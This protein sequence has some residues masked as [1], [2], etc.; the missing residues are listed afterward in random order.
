[1]RV[2]ER[3]EA[4]EYGKDDV[5]D[6][7]LWKGPKPGEPSWDTAI[8]PGPAGLAHRVLGDEHGP[9]RPVVRHPHRRRRP[10]SS[11]TT[12]TRSPR[13]RRRPAS[14]SCGPGCTAPTSRW[15]A[16]RWPS[17]PATSPGSASSSTPASSPRALRYALI[18]VH[19]RA[20]LNYSDE[21]LAAAAAGARPARRARRG[22][23]RVP[24][25]R[26]GRPD[27]A[28]RRSTR[29]GPASR[30]AL[31]DDL[32]VSAALGAAVRP[33]PRAQPPDRRALALDGGRRGRRGADP[34]PRRGARR[35]RP[36]AE[37][38]LDAE[39]QALLERARPRA[40]TATGPPPTACATSCSAR[41]SRSRTPATASAG[42]S[43]VTS[44]G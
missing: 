35:R 26:R 10:R 20:P 8:G 9:P 22:A 23:G 21:S 11:R 6:F 39:L 29:R 13:A 5:R 37:P 2:G 25:G 18:A 27:A 32:N 42:G 15:A 7:A 43:L 14:R 4:D 30:P 38:A 3:V 1:M 44:G 24:R 12:R 16:R 19:Y 17:R 28:G 34:R 41:G 31:D 36:T 33:D 40:R